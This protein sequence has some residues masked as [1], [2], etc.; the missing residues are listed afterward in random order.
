MAYDVVSGREQGSGSLFVF[1]FST[2]KEIAD[3]EAALDEHANFLRDY[4]YFLKCYLDISAT[5]YY[6]NLLVAWAREEL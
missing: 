4:A 2:L 1:A 5:T 3:M 6:T